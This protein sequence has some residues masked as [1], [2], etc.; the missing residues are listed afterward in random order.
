MQIKVKALEVGDLVSLDFNRRR[1]HLVCGMAKV[2]DVRGLVIW[3]D[4]FLINDKNV[5]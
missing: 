2:D 3:W 1:K 5:A 4:L